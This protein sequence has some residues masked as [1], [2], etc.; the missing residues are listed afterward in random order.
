MTNQFDEAPLPPQEPEPNA[1][2]PVPEQESLPPQT[3]AE[4]IATTPGKVVPPDLQISWSWAHFFV[5]LAFVLMCLVVVPLVFLTIYPPPPNLTLAQQQEYLMS[6]PQL[7]I[8]TTVVIYALVLFFMYVS[9]GLLRGLPF[10]KSL[11]WRKIAARADGKARHPILF[12]FAGCALS[13]LVFAITAGMKTP[14][15]APIEEVFKFRQTAFFFVVTAVLVAPLVEETIFRGYLYPLFARW[16]GVIP[17]IAI[18]GLLFGLMHGPQ[19][20]GAKSL[21]AVMTLVGMVFTAVRARTG[22]VVASYL[23]HLGYN[24]LIAISLALATHGF[25]QMPTNT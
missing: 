14:E 25:T 1:L 7:S 24:S 21:I 5:F 20:G 6:K 22:S 15:D 10:W 4:A 8:G 2:Q 19:L 3:I 16:F 11:G 17:S 13:L 23:M 18:T 9:L 12:V